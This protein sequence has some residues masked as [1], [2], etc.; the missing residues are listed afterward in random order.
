MTSSAQIGFHAVY[1]DEAGVP[2]ISSS[3]NA[4]VGSYLNALGLPEVA[5]LKL[6]SAAPNDMH[7]LTPREALSF[8]IEIN[9]LADDQTSGTQ[10]TPGNGA[11]GKR[12]DA[13]STAQLE[14][15][16]SD[17]VK[18]YVGFENEE[19]THDPSILSRLLMPSRLFTSEN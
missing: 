2:E 6:T 5:V 3:G 15:E 13:T 10:A 7:W 8:G 18:R 1:V 4:I 12:T 11:V 9:V 19:P 17:F 14:A 16:A